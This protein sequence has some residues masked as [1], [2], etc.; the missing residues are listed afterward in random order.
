MEFP[1][2][3]EATFQ[4]QRVDDLTESARDFIGWQ[5]KWV[6]AG[7]APEDTEYAGQPTYIPDIVAPPFAWI[8]KCDLVEEAL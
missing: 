8:P 4:P 1:W 7:M 6:Y 3:L 2:S 5:G